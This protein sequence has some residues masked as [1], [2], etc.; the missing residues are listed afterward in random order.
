MKKWRLA[1]AALAC[2]PMIASAASLEFVNQ[3]SWEIHEIH[4]S[5]ASQRNWGEDYLGSDILEKGDSLTLTG[6]EAGSWDILVIDED[7]DRCILEGIDYDTSDRD[8]W[9]ITDNDLLA[10]QSAS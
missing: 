4:V 7:G 10:C 8:R 5:P 2:S 1:M 3:S 6:L 9:V